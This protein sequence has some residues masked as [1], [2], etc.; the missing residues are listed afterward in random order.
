M[1]T[2]MPIH[3]LKSLGFLVKVTSLPKTQIYHFDDSCKA[4]YVT[5]TT[6]NK[7]HTI[8]LYKNK[9]AQWMHSVWTQ[10]F[11]QIWQTKE[12]R[13]AVVSKVEKCWKYLCLLLSIKLKQ[14][15]FELNSPVLSGVV[16]FF[17]LFLIT[18]SNVNMARLP[19][20][21]I[22]IFALITLAVQHQQSLKELKWSLLPYS[23]FLSLF[24]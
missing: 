11:V 3:Q 14:T 20:S 2:L 23:Q 15:K 6:G 16:G 24:H 21:K 8:M 4:S 18:S 7:G 10:R 12:M 1:Q 22:S 5:L 13:R 19:L 9:I 17:F